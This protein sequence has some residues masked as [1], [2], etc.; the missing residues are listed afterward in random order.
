MEQPLISIIV[1]VYNAEPY[2]DNCLDSIAAQTWENLEVWLVDDGSTD[3]SPALCDARAAADSRF[4]V[5]HQANAGVSA[6]RNAALERATGQ[7]LQFVDGD[8]YLPSTATERLVRTAGATGADLVIGRFWRVAGTRKA[9]RATFAGR[10][11]HSPGIRGGDA[12]GPGQLLLR[13][14]VEQAL[15][16]LHCGGRLRCD[17]EV[18]WCEDF[19]FNLEYP[20]ARLIAATAQPVYCYVKRPG[21]LAATQATLARTVE[22]K[23]TMF[24]AY[25]RLYQALDL[26]DEQKLRVYGYLVSAAKGRGSVSLRPPA[27]PKRRPESRAAGRAGAEPEWHNVRSPAETLLRQ[28][29]K[30]ERHSR[31]AFRLLERG[32]GAVHPDGAGPG[33][34]LVLLGD[35]QIVAGVAPGGV[36]QGEV[37]G[38]ARA[39]PGLDDLIVPQQLHGDGVGAR[40]LPSMVTGASPLCFIGRFDL[41]GDQDAGAG[42]AVGQAVIDGVPYSLG[43]RGRELA[44]MPPSTPC[45]VWWESLPA[46][47]PIR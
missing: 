2:L 3:A 12:Q 5:L 6:A 25:K 42:G 43:R 36:L 32:S 35:A 17:P 47:K 21:S 33:H 9:L 11:V 26:Y 46:V 34:V 8:D 30:A 41:Q 14:A 39:G 7:Y 40:T 24:A 4:H 19:L 1:P 18:S 10:G 31:S 37:A 45:S 27:L 23:R 16:T 28:I 13:R 38:I 15:P 29:E 44:T 20:P 22:M